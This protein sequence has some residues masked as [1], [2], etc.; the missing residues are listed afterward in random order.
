M[1]HPGI[2]WELE[3]MV[4]CGVLARHEYSFAAVAVDRQLEKDVGVR[5]TGAHQLVD[6]LVVPSE[7]FAAGITSYG[8]HGC[9]QRRKRNENKILFFFSI[10][11]VRILY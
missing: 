4:L 10:N 2:W 3:L 9:L 7:N 5:L 1:D 11:V 8:S 6:F